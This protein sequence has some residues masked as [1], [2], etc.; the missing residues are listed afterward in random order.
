MPDV[1]QL[2]GHNRL[3]GLDNKGNQVVDESVD[4]DLT[5]RYNPKK[6]FSDSAKQMF[7]KIVTL[8]SQPLVKTSGKYKKLGDRTHSLVDRLELLIASIEL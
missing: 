6:G 8:S 4:D 1:E 2:L 5:K 7:R 3:Y